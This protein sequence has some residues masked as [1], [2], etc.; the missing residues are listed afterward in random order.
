MLEGDTV[1]AAEKIV[2]IFEPHTDI[3]IKGERDVSYGHKVY[4]SGGRSSLL[5]DCVFEAGNPADS[6]LVE[7]TLERHIA[8]FGQAPRQACFD[9]GFASKANVERAKAL[10]VEDIAFHRKAGITI[11]EMVRSAWCSGGCATPARASKASSRHSSAPFRWIAAHG[12]VLSR[13]S[14]MSGLA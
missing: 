1:P 4:L 13:S 12:G 14:P 9:G 7:R 11:S 5:I 2:S 10:G 8:L 6:L 3:V